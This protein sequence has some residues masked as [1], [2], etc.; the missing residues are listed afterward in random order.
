MRMVCGQD[1]EGTLEVEV[2]AASAVAGCGEWAVSWQIA[3]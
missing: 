3:E 1:D 2:V